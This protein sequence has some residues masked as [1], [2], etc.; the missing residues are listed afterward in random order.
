MC[1]GR[2]SVHLLREHIPAE[3]DT[4]VQGHRRKV[5]TLAAFHLRPVNQRRYNA[6]HCRAQKGQQAEISVNGANAAAVFGALRA[7]LQELNYPLAWHHREPGWRHA[8]VL[9]QSPEGVS[10]RQRQQT[11]EH[12]DYVGEGREVRIYVPQR[13]G[14]R[15]CAEIDA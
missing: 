12:R 8:R 10:P 2:L 14:G 13:V 3:R 5:S 9:W 11:A 6:R 1:R 4:S 7:E 15:K